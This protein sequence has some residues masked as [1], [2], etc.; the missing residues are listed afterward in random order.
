[1]MQT[2]VNVYIPLVK[3]QTGMLLFSLSHLYRQNEEEK[4]CMAGLGN[5]SWTGFLGM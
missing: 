5:K 4:M 3:I 1:M 2:P